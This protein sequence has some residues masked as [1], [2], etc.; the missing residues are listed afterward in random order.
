[1]GRFRI[2]Y[3]PAPTPGAKRQTEIERVTA[4]VGKTLTSAD[5]KKGAIN[6]Y[7]VGQIRDGISFTNV[8]SLA[9][10][11]GMSVGDSFDFKIYVETSGDRNDA[12]AMLL[13]NPSGVSG[14]EYYGD[15]RGLASITGNCIHAFNF[16]YIDSGRMAVTVSTVLPAR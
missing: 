1:M 5:I 8:D 3:T 16:F 14:L 11:L 2:Q 12:Y 15:I 9:R 13:P 7:V 6:R 10:D 4:A